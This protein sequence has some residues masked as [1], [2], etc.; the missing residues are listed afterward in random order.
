MDRKQD[1]LSVRT[2]QH[3]AAFKTLTLLFF[4]LV[5]HLLQES[6]AIAAIVVSIINEFHRMF[7]QGPKTKTVL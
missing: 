7:S 4:C 2:K 1:M 5:Q 6:K 3:D